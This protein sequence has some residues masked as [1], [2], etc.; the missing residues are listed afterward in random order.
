M[1]RAVFWIVWNQMGVAY[2][3]RACISLCKIRPTIFKFELIS[4][5]GGEGGGF[6]L[7]DLCC[8][9]ASILPL[10][11]LV[12]AFKKMHEMLINF[13]CNPEQV[14]LIAISIY[15][16]A[17]FS[18]YQQ[19]LAYLTGW[20]AVAVGLDVVTKRKT[21]VQLHRIAGLVILLQYNTI[22]L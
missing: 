22:I 1:W 3:K 20:C 9:L 18:R 12:I 4:R 16:C 21:P 6:Y 17:I 7:V 13:V 19:W 5:R 8:F 15:S 14:L 11:L 10:H 2:T